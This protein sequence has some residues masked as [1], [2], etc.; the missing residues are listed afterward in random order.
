[1]LDK[2]RKF[3]ELQNTTFEAS[4]KKV[5]KSP[6]RV[7]K[8]GKPSSKSEQNAAKNAQV[9]GRLAKEKSQ[10]AFVDFLLS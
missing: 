2:A 5:R 10:D 9:R 1:V 8:A 6:K 7:A 3:D 4:R